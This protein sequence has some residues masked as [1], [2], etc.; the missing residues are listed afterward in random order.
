MVQNMYRAAAL[1]F[2]CEKEGGKHRVWIHP[3]VH[4]WTRQHL[5]M[6]EK[7]QQTEHALRVVAKFISWMLEETNSEKKLVFARDIL[8]DVEACVTNVIDHLQD[9]SELNC[10]NWKDFMFKKIFARQRGVQSQ[11][12]TCKTIER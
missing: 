6:S 2:T 4:A 12:C 11:L 9:R 7:Q 8:P 1:I 10:K 5:T 3:V